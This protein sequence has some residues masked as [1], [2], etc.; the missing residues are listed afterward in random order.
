MR[1]G[2]VRFCFC[3][4]LCVVEN[5]TLLLRIT[6]NKAAIYQDNIR[7]SLREMW[8]HIEQQM[9]T[10]PEG[11]HLDWDSL[12]TKDQTTVNSIHAIEAE[13]I[14]DPDIRKELSVLQE[15]DS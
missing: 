9:L 14:V 10:L 8:T 6:M 12:S 5:Y 3:F 13:W 11:D 7:R 2:G 15:D 4:D 1:D